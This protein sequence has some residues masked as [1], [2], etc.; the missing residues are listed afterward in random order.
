MGYVGLAQTQQDVEKLLIQAIQKGADVAKLKKTVA[1]PIWT[2]SPAKW[3][4]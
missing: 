1:L 4:N 2:D 3:S